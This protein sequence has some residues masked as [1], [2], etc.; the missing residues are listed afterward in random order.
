MQKRDSQA[1]GDILV[2]V[3]R[4]NGLEQKLL[5]T[6]LLELWPEVL[7]P[8]IARYTSDL[9]IHDGLLFVRVRSAALKQELFNGRFQLV[10]KLNQAAGGQVIKDI[11]LF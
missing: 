9:N 6:R 4:Q 2:E 3:L 11:R 1:L 8:T 10:E 5:E 7:G